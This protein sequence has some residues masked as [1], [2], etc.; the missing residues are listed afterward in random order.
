MENNNIIYTD[1]YL[2]SHDV[3]WFCMIDGF[4]IH[5]ASNGGNLPEII[6][7]NRL[8]S[9]EK[10]DYAYSLE[11]VFDIKD[12]EINNSY[13]DYLF[14]DT[15]KYKPYEL[16]EMRSNYLRTFVDMARRGFYSFDRCNYEEFEDDRYVLVAWPRKADEKQ[17]N[18]ILD[19]LRGIELAYS[20][21]HCKDYHYQIRINSMD[22]IIE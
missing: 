1:E 22:K 4:P 21:C 13:L 19:N 9:V 2:S 3:D 17:Y 8:N 16:I 10:Q 5:A 18:D 7:N 6:K 14:H 20:C 12:I 15:E 11:Q